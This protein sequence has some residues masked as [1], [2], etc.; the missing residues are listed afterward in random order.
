MVRALRSIKFLQF[1]SYGAETV[2]RIKKLF[3]KISICFPIIF[4]ILLTLFYL[5][6]VYANIGMIIFNTN[7][8]NYN[9][10]SPYNVNDYTNFETFFGALLILFQ[11]QNKILKRYKHKMVG[12]TIFMTMAINLI[13]TVLPFTFAPFIYYR[14]FLYFPYWWVCFGRLV[15]ILK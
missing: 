5:S 11:V 3:V 6:Y 13:I 4:R 14:C 7:T 9:L 15:V 12:Q 2:M 10:G 1:M 8:T